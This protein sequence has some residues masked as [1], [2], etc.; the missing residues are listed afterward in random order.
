MVL[1]SL[2]LTMSMFVSD[3]VYCDSYYCPDHYKLVDNAD[4]VYCK[5]KKCTKDQC[6]KK[7][8]EY[9]KH[10][11]RE[12]DDDAKCPKLELKKCILLAILQGLRGMRKKMYSVVYFQPE[13]RMVL[14]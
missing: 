3:K 9:P 5:D 8:E 12:V 1:V 10:T 13:I 4:D 2:R 6:C 14:I 7:G 11:L